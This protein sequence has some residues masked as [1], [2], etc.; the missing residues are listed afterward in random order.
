[1]QKSKN[2]NNSKKK[3]QKSK[4]IVAYGTE[5]KNCFKNIEKCLVQKPNSSDQTLE[6]VKEKSNQFES[7][8]FRMKS[9][10]W[11]SPS[12]QM[13]E[14]KK[15]S[16]VRYKKQDKKHRKS[17][18]SMK[19]IE[20]QLTCKSFQKLN[21]RV[22]E[23]IS[24][25]KTTFENDA[26]H[27]YD[28]SDKIQKHFVYKSSKGLLKD[29]KKLSSSVSKSRKAGAKLNKQIES[30]LGYSSAQS[31]NTAMMKKTRSRHHNLPLPHIYTKH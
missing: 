17:V 14:L 30:T 16:K 10:H 18:W 12:L 15:T 23:S 4:K 1:M 6:I 19:E 20:N 2:L 25:P 13:V 8:H 28:V 31:K 22:I 7:R 9:L 11:E 3:M 29:T 21:R 26:R 24:L 27:S 5:Q